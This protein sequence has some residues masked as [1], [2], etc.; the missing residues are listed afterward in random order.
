MNDEDLKV[1]EAMEQY[2]GSFVVALAGAARR[3]D[4]VNLAK[5][6][7]AFVDYWK[8]YSDVVKS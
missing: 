2:G 7:E 6:K 4:H 5:I 3:A 1:I 8:Q